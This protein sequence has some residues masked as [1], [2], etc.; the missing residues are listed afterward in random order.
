MVVERPPIATL[1]HVDAPF[2]FEAAELTSKPLAKIMQ[3]IE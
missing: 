3:S 1:D 2:A